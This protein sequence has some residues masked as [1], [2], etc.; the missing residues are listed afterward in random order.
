MHL[1]LIL[2]ILGNDGQYSVALLQRSAQKHSGSFVLPKLLGK[3]LWAA[4]G[5]SEMVEGS[6]A[7]G[8]V[9]FCWVPFVGVLCKSEGLSRLNLCVGN[10]ILSLLTREAEL[11]QGRQQPGLCCS[12]GPPGDPVIAS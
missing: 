10:R 8:M 1:D 6:K 5:V 11:F 9:C 12:L 7:D 2:S 4:A 3:F